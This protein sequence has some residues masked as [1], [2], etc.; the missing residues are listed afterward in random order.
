MSRC[1]VHI[2][3][4]EPDDAIALVDLAH[5]VDLYRGIFSGRPLTVDS[6]IHFEERFAEIIAR[7]ERIILVAEEETFV[8]SETAGA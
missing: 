6:R 5:S 8:F 7:A 2:R 1:S 4:A 3:V